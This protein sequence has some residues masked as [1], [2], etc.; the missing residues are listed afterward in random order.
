MFK[1]E[2]FYH[3]YV[4][5]KFSAHS[6]EQKEE[7]IVA[8]DLRLCIFIIHRESYLTRILGEYKEWD[9]YIFFCI[10]CRLCTMDN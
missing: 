2:Q 4:F 3:S 9:I 6:C 10:Q 1:H 5:S 7:K 8:S